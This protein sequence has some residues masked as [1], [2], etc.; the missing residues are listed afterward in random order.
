MWFNLISISGFFI[1]ILMNKFMIKTG[2]GDKINKALAIVLLVLKIVEYVYRN[3][4]GEFVF[5]IEISTIT[6]F[7]FSIT[8]IFRLKK[9]YHVVSFLS[10]ISGLGFFL[11]YSSFGFVSSLSFGIMRHVIATLCHGILLIGGLFLLYT[12]D[13][14]KTKQADLYVAILAILVH[15]AIFYVD[16]IRNTTFI[17]F[18]IKPEF[19]DV[20]INPWGNHLLLVGY[21]IV[22]F[23][24]YQQ[25]IEL[26]YKTNQNAIKLSSLKEESLK[27]TQIKSNG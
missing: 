20:F 25:A 8:V 24:I 4:R 19:L 16:T 2:N 11:Y 3:L 22:L 1:S 13:F 12:N 27:F 18:L 9:W 10:I 21:Y 17:Y 7:L 23:I 15:G 5:P 6:Y 14:S 26:F